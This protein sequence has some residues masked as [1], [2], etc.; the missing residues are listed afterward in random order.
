MQVDDSKKAA[1]WD[2]GTDGEWTTVCHATDKHP[3]CTWG[4]IVCLAVEEPL[5]R[6]STPRKT[7]EFEAQLS[8]HFAFRPAA[9]LPLP[10]ATVMY[11]YHV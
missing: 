8:R 6:L 11:K 4:L 5:W 9:M 10:S 7:P 1:P 2:E 3:S